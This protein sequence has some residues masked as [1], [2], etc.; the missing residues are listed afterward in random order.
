[1]CTERGL[2]Y[3]AGGART[4]VLAVERVDGFGESFELLEI[5]EDIYREPDA[6]V[7]LHAGVTW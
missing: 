6:K 1:V 5:V 2:A 3:V 7:V 4:G